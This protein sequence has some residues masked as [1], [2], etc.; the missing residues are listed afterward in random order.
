MSIATTEIN[1]LIWRY[2]QESG[3]EVSAYALDDES[4]VHTLD[5][6]YAPHVPLGCL[7]DLLQKGILYTKM[8]ELVNLERTEPLKQDELV[9]MNFNFFT[10]MHEIKQTEDTSKREILDTQSQQQ[11]QLQEQEQAKSMKNES[12]ITA[13]EDTNDAFI[14]VIKESSTY[15]PSSS[16]SFSPKS[17]DTIAFT[18]STLGVHASTILNISTSSQL[19]L[20]LSAHTLSTLLVEWSP[21]G[22]YVAT[23]SENGEVHLWSAVDGTLQ[24]V[25]AMHH[26]PIVSL[27][28]CPNGKFLLSLD[29][30][31]VSVVWD[32]V[33]KNAIIHIDRDS[34]IRIERDTGLFGS[35]HPTNKSIPFAT[36]VDTRQNYGTDTCWID[37]TKFITPGPAFSLLVNQL[38]CESSSSSGNGGSGSGSNTTHKAL[39]VLI[40][41]EDAISCVQYNSRLRLLASASEDGVIRIYKGNS[42][43][44]LQILTGHSLAV[45]FLC[46]INI[47]ESTHLL[48]ASLDGTVRIWDI[49]NNEILA[50]TCVDEGQA[51][52]TAAFENTTKLLATGDASGA[53]C[54]WNIGKD[55]DGEV[56][57]RQSA[58]YQHIS[59]ENSKPGIVSDLSWS[60]DGKKLAASYEQGKSVIID[61]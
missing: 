15:D 59:E 16:V 9:N 58:L 11:Q 31:N 19:Q 50:M 61:V 3:L 43:N 46:W 30:R 56:Y 39:G 23:A 28:W 10:A 29:I 60:V 21:N 5:Q 12:T 44:A 42:T 40:G 32:I 53:V 49:F 47:E 1:Y 14:K 52:L 18:Q 33:A 6:Q 26:W 55:D 54:L 24:S 57:V 38:E 27:N 22:D 35:L 13:V 45:S 48:S 8:Q 36:I 34:W 17:T 20:P 4:Q 37:D 7:V 51:V 2:L 41:H 25:L